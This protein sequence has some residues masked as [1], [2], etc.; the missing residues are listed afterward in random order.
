MIWHSLAPLAIAVGWALRHPEDLRYL[1]RRPTDWDAARLRLGYDR[2]PERPLLPPKP[3]EWRA[4]RYI[5][6]FWPVL[7]FEAERKRLGYDQ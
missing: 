4:Y 6:G 3:L 2:A 5:L 7:D 1:W